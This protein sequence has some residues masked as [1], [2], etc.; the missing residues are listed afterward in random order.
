MPR[1]VEP[2]EAGGESFVQRVVRAGSDRL[3]T[4]GSEI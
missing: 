1:A 3:W 4:E 2:E